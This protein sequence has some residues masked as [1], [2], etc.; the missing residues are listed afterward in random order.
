MRI[1]KRGFR[2]VLI[3]L[4]ALC[5]LVLVLI[6]TGAIWNALCD[7][8]DQKRFSP[9]G[10]LYDVDGVRLHL[11]CT[12]P[13]QA[14]R[15]GANQPTVI[16][17]SGFSMPAIGWVKV[18][19]L[20]AKQLRVCSY[21]RAGFGYSE[22]DATLVPQTASHMA[23]RLH[24]LL[25][26]AGVTG[27]LVLVGHSN[28]GYLVR[29]YY[30]QFPREVVGAVLVDSSSEYMDDHFVGPDWAQ[31]HIAD[32]KI[33]HQRLWLWR[34]A[35]W[36]G[37]LRLALMYAVRHPKANAP[38][39]IASEAIFLFNKPHWHPSVV[40]EGDGIVQTCAEMK[41]SRGLA[42][43]PLI[44][45]T[46]G[47]FQPRGLPE[48]DGHWNRLWVKELQP[49][50]AR[51]STRGRQVI[52]NSSHMIPFEAPDAVERAV[53]DVVAMPSFR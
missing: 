1:L 35:T 26:R 33:E 17:D 28:G 11:H 30:E 37:L 50:L 29:A 46:A 21:D 53:L 31:E 42:D 12:G 40:A 3:G 5:G 6:V 8:R 49:Q 34:A 38:L 39:E 22:P 13:A 43:L 32:Q 20:L 51:L 7:A 19:P 52:A 41:R 47:N 48:R 18:Q 15:Q 36:A 2:V 4:A 45:L 25:Q 10:Q 9:P 27:P 14:A 44:V 24:K 23:A 16:L